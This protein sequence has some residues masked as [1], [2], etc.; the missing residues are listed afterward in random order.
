MAQT[1]NTQ[2]KKVS[3]AY[4]KRSNIPITKSSLQ[5]SVEEYP[6]YPT[7]FSIS[8]IFSRYNIP[9]V[10]YRVSTDEIEK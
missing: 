4:A 8:E 2:I 10:A 5:K 1:F 6:N 7:L 3:F 9:N